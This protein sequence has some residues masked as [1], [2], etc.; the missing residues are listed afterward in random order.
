MEI[1]LGA[2]RDVLWSLL[3]LAAIVITGLIIKEET[4]G[5][6]LRNG[7]ASKGDRMPC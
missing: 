6:L 3:A 1:G 2:L 5:T 4:K 7:G